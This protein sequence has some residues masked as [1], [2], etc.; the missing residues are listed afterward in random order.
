[1]SRE[2]KFGYGFL[3]VGCALPYLIDK[4]FGPRTTSIIS[5]V[6]FLLGAALLVSAHIP[7]DKGVRNKYGNIATAVSL[8]I[9]IIAM[10]TL[11]IGIIRITPKA[12]PA[13]DFANSAPELLRV[14]T[15]I[16]ILGTAEGP[17][18]SDFNCSDVTCLEE[19]SVSGKTLS[20]SFHRK[21]RTSIAILVK[22]YAGMSLEGLYADQLYS[23]RIAVTTSAKEIGL[24]Y[25]DQRMRPL[26]NNLEFSEIGWFPTSQE[27]KPYRFVVDIELTAPVKTFPLTITVQGM[28]MST[29]TTTVDF[30]VTDAKTI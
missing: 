23:P 3:L 17:Y 21:N 27:Q 5:G 18:V 19:E 7:E 2:T 25:H 10:V 24:S 20:L 12:T 11:I 14:E 9:A 22:C 28:N 30:T 26:R 13:P 16:A 15:G 4:M 29:H 8:V 1:M 6:F